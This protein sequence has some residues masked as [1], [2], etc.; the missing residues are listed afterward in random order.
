MLPKTATAPLEE[1]LISLND[2]GAELAIVTR[3][4]E[5]G[6]EIEGSMVS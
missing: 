2:W 4:R 5:I 3:T 6:K 1:K